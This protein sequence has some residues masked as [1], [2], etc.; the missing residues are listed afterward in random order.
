MAYVGVEPHCRITGLESGTCYWICVRARNIAGVG[1]WSSPRDFRTV[2]DLGMVSGCTQSLLDFHDAL[3]PVATASSTRPDWAGAFS[4][5]V[6]LPGRRP[7]SMDAAITL[8]VAQGEQARAS[9]P[10]PPCGKRD[11]HVKHVF[12]DLDRCVSLVAFAPRAHS[13]SLSLAMVPGIFRASAN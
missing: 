11:W 1:P 10:S 8:S 9:N 13:V 5:A 6:L 3:D 12:Q 2:L 4:P 7:H